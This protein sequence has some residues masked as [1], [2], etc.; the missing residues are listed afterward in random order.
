MRIAVVSGTI[1]GQLSA[2]MLDRVW[3]AGFEPIKLGVFEAKLTE[4]EGQ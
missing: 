1:S 2:A 4:L 3:V